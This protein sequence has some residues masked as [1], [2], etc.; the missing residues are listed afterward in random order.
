MVARL[1]GRLPRH[2][3][4]AT[5]V[6]RTAPGNNRDAGKP[7][8]DG[9]GRS[10]GATVFDEKHVDL[11]SICD[12]IRGYSERFEAAER[13]LPPI[14]AGHQRGD[15]PPHNRTARST[16]EFIGAG[17]DPRGRRRQ[18]KTR[19]RFVASGCAD[20]CG[21]SRCRSTAASGSRV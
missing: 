4:A 5:P 7:L 3:H 17:A 20:R 9:L 21:A 18:K 11:H 6:E 14:V 16:H 12:A 19:L 8:R 13:E 1:H 15:P 2:P 10:V